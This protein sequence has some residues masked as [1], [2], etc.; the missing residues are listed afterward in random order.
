MLVMLHVCWSHHGFHARLAGI[1]GDLELDAAEAE[2]D[3]ALDLLHH[4]AF[5]EAGIERAETNVVL[6][7][8]AHDL[9]GLVVDDAHL[10][11]GGMRAKD[12]HVTERHHL[13]DALGE[14]L[15]G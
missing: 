10:L 12:E 4:G 8:P 15:V 7:P 2:A 11:F 5:A 3:A 1:V 14:G 13:R 9:V 6:G